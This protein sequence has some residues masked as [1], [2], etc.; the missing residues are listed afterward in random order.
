MKVA[1]FS[2]AVGKFASDRGYRLIRDL[3]SHGFGRSLHGAAGEITTWPTRGDTWRMNKGLM[4]TVEPSLSTGGL[5]ATERD[6]AW[7]L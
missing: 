6:Y 3:T 7:T 1:L 4:L 5:W 2:Q